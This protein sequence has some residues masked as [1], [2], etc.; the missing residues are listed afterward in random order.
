ML[1]FSDAWLFNFGRVHIWQNMLGRIISCMRSKCD[2]I[3]STKIYLYM[4]SIWWCDLTFVTILWQWSVLLRGILKCAIFSMWPH[5][6]YTRHWI[7]NIVDCHYTVSLHHIRISGFFYLR[8]AID[9]IHENGFDKTYSSFFDVENVHA[10]MDIMICELCPLSTVSYNP[11]LHV[12]SW[13]KSIW[14]W[15]TCDLFPV[16]SYWK[17][18][19]ND[20]NVFEDLG[21][22]IYNRIALVQDTLHNKRQCCV[23]LW[24]YSAIN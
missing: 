10:I 8:L 6:S 14:S 7:L 18:Q 2:F 13:R 4:P 22:T 3:T 20:N 21:M 19:T 17:Q 1:V 11:R 9:M 16:P 5:L 15:N 23:H 24:K 12:I